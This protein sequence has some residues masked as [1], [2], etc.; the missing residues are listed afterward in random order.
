VAESLIGELQARNLWGH[1]SGGRVAILTEEDSVYGRALQKTY[2]GKAETA[3]G[4][5]STWLQN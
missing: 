5:A 4:N 2:A 3:Y 1:G